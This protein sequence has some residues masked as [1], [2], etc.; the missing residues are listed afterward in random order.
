M[1]VQRKIPFTAKDGSGMGWL[2]VYS[3]SAGDGWR[4]ARAKYNGEWNTGR[5]QVRNNKICT[6]WT[7]G[8]TLKGTSQ[9]LRVP[10]HHHHYHKTRHHHGHKVTK[11]Y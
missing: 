6:E 5:W 3:N 10:R 1:F 2:C 4:F 11:F 9:C 7:V 8:A